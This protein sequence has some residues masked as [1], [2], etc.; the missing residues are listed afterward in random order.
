MGLALGSAFFGQACRTTAAAFKAFGRKG[1]AKVNIFDT[2]DT[3]FR[4]D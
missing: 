1:R 4:F 2:N 3:Q